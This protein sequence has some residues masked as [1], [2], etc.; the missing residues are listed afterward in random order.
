[1]MGFTEPAAKAETSDK[2][3]VLLR[4]SKGLHG[5]G[6]QIKRCTMLNVKSV[7]VNERMRKEGKL[8]GVYALQCCSRR[9]ALC[10]CDL[11]TSPRDPHIEIPTS[12]NWDCCQVSNAFNSSFDV[13]SRQWIN[14]MLSMIIDERVRNEH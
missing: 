7:W 13:C 2:L 8:T 10:A 14:A 12:E 5:F 6:R 9:P 3:S 1:M 4:S 11:V